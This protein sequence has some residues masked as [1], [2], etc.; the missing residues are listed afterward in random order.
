MLE[1][2]GKNRNPDRGRLLRRRRATHRAASQNYGD[3]LDCMPGFGKALGS[4]R[5]LRR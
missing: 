1:D 4:R 3:P 5:W 2:Y